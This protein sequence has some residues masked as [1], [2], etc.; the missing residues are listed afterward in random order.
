[1][2][3]MFLALAELSLT[4][5]RTLEAHSYTSVMG[6]E[7]DVHCTLYIEYI[8]LCFFPQDTL[9]VCWAFD[10][11]KRPTFS[12]LLRTLERLPKQR[13]RLHRSPSQPCTVGRGAEALI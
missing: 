5:P 4:T 7:Y 8:Y 3:S 6:N 9:T 11:D 2:T 13:Q 10:P 1:M 12:N